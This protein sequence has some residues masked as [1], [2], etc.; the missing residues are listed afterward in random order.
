MSSPHLNSF[1]R[2]LSLR[3]HFLFFRLI[4]TS[5][6][7]VTL[8]SAQLTFNSLPSNVVTPDIQP[9]TLH[10]WNGNA[11]TQLHLLTDLMFFFSIFF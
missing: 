1:G 10:R 3:R 7:F 8:N 4:V 11:T 2:F 5:S 9:V 6:H